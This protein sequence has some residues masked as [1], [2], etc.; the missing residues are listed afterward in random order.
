MSKAPD[1]TRKALGKG[2]SALLPSKAAAS[3]PK[4]EVLS[5]ASG[6]KFYRR[7]STGVCKL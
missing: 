7:N 4:P 5:E 2:L 3:A 1:K 6:G